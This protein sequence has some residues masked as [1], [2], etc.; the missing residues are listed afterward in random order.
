MS[1]VSTCLWFAHDAEGAARFYVSLE[2]G[3][4]DT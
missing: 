1:T 4:S 2:P 3:T